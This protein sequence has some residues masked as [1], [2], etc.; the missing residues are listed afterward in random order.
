[1]ARH[2]PPEEMLLDYAAGALGEAESLLVATHLALCTAC[3][4]DVAAM[5]AV[6]GALLETIP[7]G[8][9]ATPG[10]DD[11]LASVMARLDEPD[12]ARIAVRPPASGGAR[13][14]LPEPLRSYLGCDIAGIPWQPVMRGLDERPIDLGGRGAG[15]RAGA[16][17]RM[18]RI[19]PA[20]AMPQHTHRGREMTLVLAGGFRDATG[21]YGR[22]DL[23]LTD[24]SVDH[25]PVADAD[26]ACVCLVAT[27]APV[28]L[29]G[30]L[31]RLFN[32]F[33]R[34]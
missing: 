5:E 11:V 16:K 21:H 4:A 30:V 22:G 2:H 23:A 14:A 31:G 34:F 25:T 8:P 1:M 12:A 20:T 7:A 28:R 17:V 10:L 19:H 6:G 9:E 3:R 32:P 26:E 33:V 18:L 13:P 15:S 27:E 29:T 24:A